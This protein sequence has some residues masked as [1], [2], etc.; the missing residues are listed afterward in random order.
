MQTQTRGSRPSVG[1]STRAMP[2]RF[3]DSMADNHTCECISILFEHIWRWLETFVENGKRTQKGA[4][5]NSQPFWTEKREDSRLGKSARPWRF[6]ALGSLDLTASGTRRGTLSMKR[7]WDCDRRNLATPC[8]DGA[9]WGA[10]VGCGSDASC[11]CWRFGA[12][13]VLYVFCVQTISNNHF[14]IFFSHV[15][16]FP[17]LGSCFGWRLR[18]A[19]ADCRSWLTQTRIRTRKLHRQGSWLGRLKRFIEWE[20][21]RVFSFL[22]TNSSQAKSSHTMSQPDVSAQAFRKLS[23]SMRWV[24]C[25]VQKKT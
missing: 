1:S 19:A 2:S 20:V 4:N 15:L 18:V 5:C 14:F 3:G 7:C 11:I 8:W 6:V 10:L 16:R 13:Y 9:F 23:D 22:L 17:F 12:F 21:L 24:V 25:C